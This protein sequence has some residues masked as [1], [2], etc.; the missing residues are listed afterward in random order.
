MFG[1]T[2]AQHCFAATARLMQQ[3]ADIP[4]DRAR[5]V[6]IRKNIA[7]YLETTGHHALAV[8]AFRQTVTILLEVAYSSDEPTLDAVRECCEGISDS[9]PRAVDTMSKLNRELRARATLLTL[10]RYGEESLETVE[11]LQAQRAADD[12]QSTQ[13]K[14]TYRIL[15][16]L[17][18]MCS[19]QMIWTREA[20]K[21]Y[22]AAAGVLYSELAAANDDVRLSQLQSRMANTAVEP[23]ALAS[24]GP[25]EYFGAIM[26]QYSSEL[27]RSPQNAQ[28]LADQ[29]R[30]VAEVN[31]NLHAKSNAV[32]VAERLVESREVYASVL[33]WTGYR[34]QAV[35]EWERA[36]EDHKEILA[37]LPPEKI[38]VQYE[39]LLKHAE[40]LALAQ[41]H[42]TAASFLDSAAGLK[43]SQARPSWKRGVQPD[44]HTFFAEVLYDVALEEGGN[45]EEAARRLK[46]LVAATL[47]GDYSAEA[48]QEVSDLRYLLLAIRYREKGPGSLNN[49]VWSEQEEIVL[50]RFKQR[51]LELASSFS[52]GD[53]IHGQKLALINW[54]AWALGN[55][56]GFPL[57]AAELYRLVADAVMCT[58]GD[59]SVLVF[60]A[61]EMAAEMLDRADDWTGGR[62]LRSELADRC[63]AI[64]SQ[65]DAARSPGSAESADW[66]RRQVQYLGQSERYVD[67]ERVIEQ[68][69]NDTIV[70]L[71]EK[72]GRV[73]QIAAEQ[74]QYDLRDLRRWAAHR[75]GSS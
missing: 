69:Y 22:F 73:A 63:G 3:W 54:I 23:L 30:A 37:M 8:E 58:R 56:L 10:R 49:M 39:Q 75:D 21:R 61:L 35:V 42:D 67:V 19:E 2:T 62:A 50:R 52:V 14:I 1:T 28:E 6:T 36:V 59:D 65:I 33:A 5:V 60:D 7:E 47:A 12:T 11:A 9:D 44:V 70:S 64:A 41:Q 32:K 31:L 17:D 13:D 4:K 29:M 48:V 46:S 43:M 57:E 24:G 26:E 53:D 74:R 66:R 40:L 71:T 55:G 27:Q 51:S 20:L 18:G 34:E 25:Q 45:P 15:D 16:I 38:D 72:D 68:I